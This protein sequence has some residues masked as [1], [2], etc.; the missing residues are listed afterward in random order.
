MYLAM[1]KA[2][3]TLTRDALG[4]GNKHFSRENEEEK[5]NFVKFQ[6]DSSEH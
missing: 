2:L 5:K 3:V 4:G 1:W 6:L